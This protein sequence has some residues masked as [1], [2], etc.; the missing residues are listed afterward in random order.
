MRRSR[1]PSPPETVTT[2]STPTDDPIKR[3]WSTKGGIG[4]I[5]VHAKFR[6]LRADRHLLGLGTV[7]QYQAPVSSKSEWLMG[8]P[9]GGALSGKMIVDIEPVS[10]YRAAAN[11]GARIPLGY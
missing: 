8:E 1:S 9:G 5:A 6:W 11:V 3:G 10:W 7:I 2:G 4:D